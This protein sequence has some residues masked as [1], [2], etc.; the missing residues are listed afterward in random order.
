MIILHLKAGSTPKGNV[1][2][3]F[4]IFD[5]L[6][7][8]VIDVVDADRCGRRALRRRYGKRLDEEAVELGSILT[9]P[10]EIRRF[11]RLANL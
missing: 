5:D 11:R 2:R 7:G 6:N 1:R 4:V 3:A 10:G 8:H 9:T